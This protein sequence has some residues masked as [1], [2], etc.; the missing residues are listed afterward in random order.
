[1]QRCSA[2]EAT[3]RSTQWPDQKYGAPE[4]SDNAKRIGDV[5][6]LSAAE[7]NRR[8][9]MPP[10]SKS[11]NDCEISLDGFKLMLKSRVDADAR[12]GIWEGV[13]S[14]ETRWRLVIEIRL[15]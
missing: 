5:K 11:V 2:A 14:T 15:E 13:S 12:R 3:Q 7:S 4:V 8:E 9:V 1:M 10:Y 6:S